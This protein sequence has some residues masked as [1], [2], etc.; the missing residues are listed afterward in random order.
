[1]YWGHNDYPQY[2]GIDIL[3]N[4]DLFFYYKHTIDSEKV[5]IWTETTTKSNT[6]YFMWYGGNTINYDYDYSKT[7]T[8]REIEMYLMPMQN[9]I[10]LS[11]IQ[12][13][14]RQS[15][16]IIDKLIYNSYVSV[17]GGGDL[18]ANGIYKQYGSNNDKAEYHKI[19]AFDENN[20]IVDSQRESTITYNNTNNWTITSKNNDN[21]ETFDTERYLYATSNDGYYF[22]PRINAGYNSI[23]GDIKGFV[24]KNS[25]KAPI[26]TVVGGFRNSS[27][28]IISKLTNGDFNKWDNDYYILPDNI[29]RRNLRSYKDIN[30]K[31]RY[32]VS[33]KITMKENIDISGIDLY[34]HNHE[35]NISEGLDI[36]AVY[37]ENCLTELGVLAQPTLYE[38]NMNDIYTNK[39]DLYFTNKGYNTDNYNDWYHDLGS[40]GFLNGTGGSDYIGS[41]KDGTGDQYLSQIANDWFSIHC[42]NNDDGSWS[43]LM[44]TDKP[45]NV[46]SFIHYN[47]TRVSHYQFGLVDEDEWV[48]MVH[49]IIRFLK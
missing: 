10:A 34:L 23:F 2:V 20:F 49:I 8:N 21:T 37:P 28:N 26:P 1:M 32:Y 47:A 40:I 33:L 4:G 39:V 38:V 45:I 18:Y 36:V 42:A 11:E 22:N 25:A 27:S 46:K 3:D 9:P 35:N 6:E 19:T 5:E 29:D 16:N 13:N 7:N 12:I 30:G 48:E 24:R 43:T 14:N 31:R 41:W 44:T 17:T 15:N